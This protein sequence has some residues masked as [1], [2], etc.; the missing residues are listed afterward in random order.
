[1][2]SNSN[3]RLTDL[4]TVLYSPNGLYQN[5]KITENDDY[6]LLNDISIKYIGE[7]DLFE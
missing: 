2:F 3:V 6:V 1:M 7:T 4:L 5:S